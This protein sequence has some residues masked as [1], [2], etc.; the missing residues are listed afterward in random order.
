[1]LL[2]RLLADQAYILSYWLSSNDEINYR[3]FFTINNLVGVRVEDPLV[4]EA[5]HAVILRLV[6][7]GLVTG[8]RID[9]VDG[10]RDPHAYLRRLQE[11]VGGNAGNGSHPPFYVIVEKILAYGEILPSEW[12]ICGATGYASLNALNGL[13]IDG[14]GCKKLH[15]IYESSIGSRAPYEDLVYEKKKQVMESLLTVEM[16]SLGHYLPSWLSRTGTHVICGEPTS[17]GPSRRP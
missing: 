5:I 3:R 1:M 2:D 11:R 8:L 4:F 10:L 17:R 15:Q 13:F 9:H 12:S 6:D 14:A 7:R 16:R